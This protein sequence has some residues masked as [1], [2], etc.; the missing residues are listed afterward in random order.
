MRF[1]AFVLTGIVAISFANIFEA[2]AKGEP[3]PQG[4]DELPSPEAK[5]KKKKKK[6]KEQIQWS[7]RVF[8]RDTATRQRIAGE[9]YWRNSQFVDS[10]RVGMRYK[11]K[12]GARAVIKL[13]IKDDDP[14]LRDA[15]IRLRP[16]ASLEVNAGR[17][18]TPISVI[19]LASKWDLPSVERGLLDALRVEGQ[20]LPFL[21]DREDG[22]TLRYE[23]PTSVAVALT[24]GLFQNKLGTGD[25]SLDAAKAFAQ[26]AFLRA[27]V[28]PFDDFEIASSLAFFG[29]LGQVGDPDSFEHA[30][31]G[32]ME[33]AYTPRWLLFWGEGYVGKSMFAKADG[34]TSGNFFGAR[35]L[36]AANL[37][38]GV[39]R[40]LQ[41]FAG[42]SYFDPRQDEPDDANT[43]V[44]GGVSLAF[45]KIWRLQVEVAHTFAQG[46]F[47]SATAGTAFHL[48]LGARFKP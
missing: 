27:S 31:V 1:R 23:L 43:E 44:Q 29:H 18:K 17:F 8:V 48:Q 30:P 38:P 47:S 33:I 42:V 26:D 6:K 19:G 35:A 37:R 12:S 13:E 39:P 36:V 28:E 45:T 7:G 46:F 9:T 34:S 3:I 21:G 15:Y 24:A 25:V 4:F 40:R 2:N 16:L 10:A 14:E 22:V 11:H 5:K 32:S 20:R 41:P